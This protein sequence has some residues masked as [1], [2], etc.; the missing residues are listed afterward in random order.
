MQIKL[1]LTV[2]V[3]NDVYKYYTNPEIYKT[4]SYQPNLTFCDY[5]YISKVIP[6]FSHSLKLSFYFNIR[7]IPLFAME[8]YFHNF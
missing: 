4:S 5:V 2:S 3:D 6:V 7:N 1:T 8:Q